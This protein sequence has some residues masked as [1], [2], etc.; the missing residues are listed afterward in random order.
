MTFEF[1]TVFKSFL[2]YKWY[3]ASG[4][5]ERCTERGVDGLL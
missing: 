1:L 2:A 4:Q 3:N 5:S